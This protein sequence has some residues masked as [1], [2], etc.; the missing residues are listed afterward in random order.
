MEF[1]RDARGVA[2]IEVHENIPADDEIKRLRAIEGERIDRGLQ[3]QIGN[4]QHGFQAWCDMKRRSLPLKILF[5][6]PGRCMA[7]RPLSVNARRSLVQ[8]SIVDIRRVNT[9][10]PCGHY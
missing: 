4:I 7:E 8:K 2:S 1:L 6:N 3:I 5:A 9:D 10:V